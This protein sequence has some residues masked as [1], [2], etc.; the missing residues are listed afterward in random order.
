[1]CGCNKKVSKTRP[2]SAKKTILRKMWEKS[3]IEEKPIKINRI[4]KS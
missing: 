4:N 3:K 2:V 1:M